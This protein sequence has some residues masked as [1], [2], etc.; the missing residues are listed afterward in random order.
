MPLLVQYDASAAGASALS[1]KRANI[2][3]DLIPVNLDYLEPL[4]EDKVRIRC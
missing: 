2:I 1:A 4:A 3:L